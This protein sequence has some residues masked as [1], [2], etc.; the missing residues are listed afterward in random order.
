MCLLKN[1]DLS[2]KIDSLFQNN[3]SLFHRIQAK[4]KEFEEENEEEAVEEETESEVE[5]E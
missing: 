2:D 1:L 3:T 5:E 4:L